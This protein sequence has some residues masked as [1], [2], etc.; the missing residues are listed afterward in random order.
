MADEDGGNTYTLDPKEREKARDARLKPMRPP[1]AWAQQGNDEPIPANKIPGLNAAAVTSG[2]F[3]V[4]RMP[5]QMVE[6]FN[7]LV[8]KIEMLEQKVKMLER[9]AV[10]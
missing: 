7:K 10:K 8:R 3:N 1:A 2:Q 5:S 4:T 6:S 9:M